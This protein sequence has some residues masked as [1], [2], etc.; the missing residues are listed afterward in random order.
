MKRT[1]TLAALALALS[2]VCAAAEPTLAEAYRTLASKRF[3]DLTHAFAPGI[4]HW[5][6]FGELPWR[7]ATEPMSDRVVSCGDG[8]T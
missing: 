2:G 6:G 3:V 5:K 7:D 8:C 1:L 4:P